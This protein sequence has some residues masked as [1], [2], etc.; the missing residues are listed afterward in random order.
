MPPETKYDKHIDFKDGVRVQICEIDQLEWYAR[1]IPEQFT[2]S[3]CLS[4]IRF[5]LP[6]KV[7]PAPDVTIVGT[8]T[9]A[10]AY[11]CLG[12]RAKKVFE[13]NGQRITPGSRYAPFNA[14]FT[15]QLMPFLK[16]HDDPPFRIYR[17]RLSGADVLEVHALRDD[18]RNQ[19]DLL[20]LWFVPDERDGPREHIAS[21][22]SRPKGW[23]E[24]TLE[25]RTKLTPEEIASARCFA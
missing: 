13:Y 25:E 14:I 10:E 12:E 7:L 11:L 16:S 15:T 23:K 19:N 5:L 6:W 17:I 1:G 2:G 18:I 24:I 4:A 22:V 21:I 20:D 9:D 3:R 8:L